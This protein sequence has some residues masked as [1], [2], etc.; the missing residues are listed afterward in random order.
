[1]CDIKVKYEAPNICRGC[2]SADRKLAPVAPGDLYFSLLTEDQKVEALTIPQVELCWEC[3]A[4]LSRIRRFQAQVQSA[5]SILQESLQFPPTK[6]TFS[7][8]K[9][10]YK[11]EYDAVIEDKKVFEKLSVSEEQQLTTANEKVII[12]TKY[13]TTNKTNNVENVKS[14]KDVINDLLKN[15][16]VKKDDKSKCP[17]NDSDEDV[18]EDNDNDNF[19]GDE[20]NYSSPVEVSD[21][22]DDSLKTLPVTANNTLSKVKQPQQNNV[23]ITRQAIK[24]FSQKVDIPILTQPNTNNGTAKEEAT[25][26]LNQKVDAKKFIKTPAM[27]KLEMELK[28]HMSVVKPVPKEAPSKTRK[29]RAERKATADINDAQSDHDDDEPETKKPK[30]TELDPDFSLDEDTDADTDNSEE[31]KPLGISKPKEREGDGETERHRKFKKTITNYKNIA[32]VTPYFTEIEMGEQEIRSAL[33]KDDA[34]VKENKPTKCVICGMAFTHRRALKRHGLAYHRRL[35]PQQYRK[36]AWYNPPPE[37]PA[38][39]VWRCGP[40]GRLLRETHALAHMNEYHKV[41]YFCNGS[42]CEWC[43]RCFWEKEDFDQH[44]DEIHRKTVCDYCKK[45]KKNKRSLEM[46]MQTSHAKL[47]KPVIPQCK[48]CA[49]VFPSFKSLSNHR[50]NAHRRREEPAEQRYCV[51]CD[52]T[53]KRIATFQKH[54]LDRHSGVPKPTYPCE[55]CGKELAN[56]NSYQKHVA[57]LHMGK[58]NFCCHICGKYM[59]SSQ[60]LKMHLDSHL[61][62]KPPKTKKCDICG[63]LFSNDRTLRHHTYTHTGERP[64]ACPHGDAAFT[65]PHCLRAHLL[66]QHGVDARVKTDGTITLLNEPTGT[67]T[68][69]T[70][71]LTGVTEVE[72]EK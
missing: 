36:G 50:H 8:L 48:E 71:M 15:L 17:S 37:Y 16:N 61:N 38:R 52:V 9:I 56:K 67:I 69:G 35:Y 39:S 64:Y 12:P 63:R 53:F 42:G 18:D 13:K 47:V 54:F 55:Y 65:Q 43:Q 26:T 2:L 25:T 4:L 68:E 28:K 60:A 14:F 19:D 59:S 10:H 20:T 3:V 30:Q 29:K 27:L 41:Q 46:H 44:W 58:T 45:P 22:E 51:E 66:K 32:E 6:P 70:G 33:E 5:H 11:F 23:K 72:M 57:L 1:M 31:F 34:I 49:A 21:I 7:S 62:I 40:C 24:T